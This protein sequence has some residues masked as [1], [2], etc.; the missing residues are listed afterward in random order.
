M[1]VDNIDKIKVY[2][3]PPLAFEGNK[4]LWYKNYKEILNEFGD[5]EIFVDLFGGSGILSHWTKNIYK[6]AIVIYNDFDNYRE[7]LNNIPTTNELMA[8]LRNIL[9][10]VPTRKIIDDEHINQIKLLFEQYKNNNKFIDL[11]TLSHQLHFSKRVN[12]NT[13]D[14]DKFLKDKLYNNIN[15]NDIEYDGKYLDGI[16]VVSMDWYKLYNYCKE[17]FKEYKICFILDPPYLYTD[18]SLYNCRYWKLKDSINLLDILKHY[19]FIF[20]NSSKSGFKELVEIINRIFDIG[21]TYKFIQ[22]DMVCIYEKR[23]DY[24]MYS[25]KNYFKEII[26][27]LLKFAKSI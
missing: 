26:T 6:N 8:D 27:T 22:Q 18:K 16:N 20:F 10:D 11:K 1:S 25:N 15:K 14:I 24:C 3:K 4:K 21:I 23:I 7:R 13:N 19:P 12:I 5:V 2:T 9:K 17:T